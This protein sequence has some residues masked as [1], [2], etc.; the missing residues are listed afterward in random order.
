MIH[1]IQD[2]NYL[3]EN[4]QQQQQ[5]RKICSGLLV[6]WGQAKTVKDRR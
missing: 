3:V 6:T 1:Y 4:R 5:Q 2:T